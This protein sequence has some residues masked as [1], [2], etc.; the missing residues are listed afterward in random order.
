MPSSLKIACLILIIAID[1]PAGSGKSSTARGVAR[2]LGYL[3]LDTGAMYRA[4]AL[5]F[6]RNKAAATAE[7]AGRLLPELTL[8]V[9]YQ[10][11][12][13]Q[14]L[15]DG[16]VVSEA[17]RDPEVGQMASRVSTL[18][19]VR[20]KL[21]AEQQRIGQTFREH[22]GVVIDGRDIGTVVFPDADLKIFM[23]ADAQVRAQR[24]QDEL[25]E[26][27][28]VVPFEEVLAEMRQRDRQDT[29]RAHSPLRRADDAIDLDT[30]HCTLEDQI[31]FVIDKAGERA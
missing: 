18:P 11:G 5:A 1:G 15:L 30:T 24:R 31:Q 16:T 4:V 20:E 14:V 27:G 21:V 3:Y 17:I 25:A 6:L 7:A 28:T 8:D 2:R 10:N 12:E 13:M 9:R 23:I 26:K 29:E 22:P 19:A